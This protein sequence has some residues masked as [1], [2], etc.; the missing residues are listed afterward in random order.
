MRL[1]GKHRHILTGMRLGLD[2]ES[3][4]KA[5]ARNQFMYV[6]VATA[7]PKVL[8]NQPTFSNRDSILAGVLGTPS[9]KF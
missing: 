4:A 1:V 9:S 7:T 2:S 6:G 5:T 8:S 3:A